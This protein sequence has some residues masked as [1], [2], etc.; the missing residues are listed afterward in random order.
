MNIYVLFQDGKRMHGKFGGL[1]TSRKEARAKKQTA[2]KSRN[3][4]GRV[5]IGRF[6]LD[7]NEAEQVR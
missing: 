6:Q 7:M 5:T 3:V 4:S 2:Q 1:F